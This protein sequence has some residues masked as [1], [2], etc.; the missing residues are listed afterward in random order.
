MAFDKEGNLPRTVIVEA[1]TLVVTRVYCGEYDGT[2][3]TMVRCTSPHS[4]TVYL[5]RLIHLS[6]ACKRTT[7]PPAVSAA[8]SSS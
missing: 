8:T 6:D 7:H 5:P 3:S 2:G 1:S 4:R